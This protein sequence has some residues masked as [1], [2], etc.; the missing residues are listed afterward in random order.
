[1]IEID[2]DMIPLLQKRFSKDQIELYWSDVLKINISKGNTSSNKKNTFFQVH[3]EIKEII[4]PEYE[5]YGNI[6]YY[7]TSPII[8]HFFYTVNFPPNKATFTMQKEVAERILARDGKHSV[9]SVSC[10]LVADVEKVCD[11]NPQSF[12]P[13]PKV[14]SSCLRFTLKKDVSIQDSREIIKIVKQGFSQKRKKLM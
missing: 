12:D 11:I 3:K 1:M 13:V 8:Y 7:I 10:Q 14:W 4:I 9:L 6:P 5:L 2:S